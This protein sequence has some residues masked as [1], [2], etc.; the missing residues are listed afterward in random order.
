MHAINRLPMRPVF[1]TEPWLHQLACTYIGLCYPRFLFLL[2]MGLGKSKILLDLLTHALRAGEVT[3]GMIVVPRLINIDSWLDAIRQHSDLEPWPINCPDIKEKRHRLLNPKGDITIVDYQGLS[4]GLCDKVKGKLVIN[5]D[6]VRRC[7]TRHQ[8]LG[9][10]ESHK[11]ANVDSL[12]FSVVDEIAARAK[13]VHATT[14]TLFGSHVERAWPQFFLV[15]RGETL[16]VDRA[17]FMASFFIGEATPFKGVVMKF[18]KRKARRLH[19]MLQHRS[20]RYDDVEVHDLPLLVHRQRMVEMVGDQLEHY[21]RAVDG[22]IAT[23]NGNPSALAAPWLRMRQI[24]SGYLRWKDEYGDHQVTFPSNPKLDML[25]TMVLDELTDSKVI[26]CHDYTDTGQ[27]IVDRLQAAG[28]PCVWLYG[29]TKDKPAARR[30]FLDPAG[31]RVLVMNSE[32]G[33]TGVDELQHVARYMIF[34]ESPTPPDTRRQTEKRI[35]RPGQKQRCFVYDLVTRGTVDVSILRA[36]SEGHDMHD[37]V[38]K[39]SQ[40]Q[41]KNLLLGR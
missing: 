8:F 24:A 32:A 9:A 12:W 1:K 11:V 13:H 19:L 10:D 22:V 31:P 28:T 34:Y 26:I 27:M 29:G 5:D 18:D 3:H 2:D 17:V 4:L 39:G 40:G 14:G 30:R 21:T 15:D 36:L 16:G 23:A 20:I 38:V 6:A 7:A 37:R 25:E 35:H 33:G 41:M